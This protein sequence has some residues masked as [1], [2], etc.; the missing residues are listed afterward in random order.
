LAQEKLM[1]VS[2]FD[3][4]IL[5]YAA[6]PALEQKDEFKRP[7]AIDLLANEDFVIS[8]QV[9]AEFYHNIVRKGKIRLT[10]EQALEWIHSMM[11]RPCAAVDPAMILAG[12][13]FSERFQISYWD[14]AMLAAANG[15]GAEKFYS[16]DLNDGQL[17]GAVTVVNPFKQLAN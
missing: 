4:N 10:H 2:F 17:Y 5:I 3:T 16:E 12:A 14:G 13:A 9:L 15:M 11:E 7:I 8:G 6:R 1:P